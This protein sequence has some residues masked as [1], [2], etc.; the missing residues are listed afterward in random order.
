[1]KIRKS[2]LFSE[3][4]ISSATLEL[5]TKQMSV[6]LSSG[7]TLEK[8][9]HI[10]ELQCRGRTSKIFKELSLSI[11]SGHSFAKALSKYPRDFSDV[12]RG[13]VFAG[14]NSGQL[15]EVFFKLS[16]FLEMRNSLKKSILTALTYPFIVVLMS[17]LIIIL[18]M[19]YVVPE[20]TTVYTSQSR[21]LPLLTIGLIFISDFLIKWGASIS[22]LLGFLLVMMTVAYSKKTK[23]RIFCDFFLLKLPVIG[24]LML[25]SEMAMF[26]NTLNMSISGGLDLLK[27]LQIT[28]R[29]TSNMHL[30]L[31]I[32]KVINMVREGV[33]LG[34]A[35]SKTAAYPK[36]L[37]QLITIGEETGQLAKMLDLCA[38][39]SIEQFKSQSN[40][41]AI[42]LEPL[43]ILSMG[44]LVMLIVLAVMMP[45]IEMNVVI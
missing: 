3:T 19:A 10:I 33:P 24:K 39:Q 34:K 29:V 12:Y 5:L 11:Q 37:P 25:L 27:S 31:N 1:M 13:F 17:S 35:L 45:L 44:V 8:T 41:V 22:L 15:S 38:R 40:T 21:E 26:A 7:V 28:H 43:L 9:L 4:K 42:F 18:L 2:S 30:L 14:E 16:K 6:L 32:K 23:F 20:I 36:L